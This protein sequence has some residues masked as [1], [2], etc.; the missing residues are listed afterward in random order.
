MADDISL[1]QFTAMDRAA[2]VAAYVSA[3]EA[4]DAIPELQEL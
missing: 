3:L 1:K 2:D 4:F